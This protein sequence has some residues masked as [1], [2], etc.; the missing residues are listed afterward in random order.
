MSIET[1]T[2]RHR[3]SNLRLSQQK[4]GETRKR[5][6]HSGGLITVVKHVTTVGGNTPSPGGKYGTKIE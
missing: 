3:F 1:E 6:G 5:A 4:R 2:I